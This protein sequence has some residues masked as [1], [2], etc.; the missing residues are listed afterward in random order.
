M[1]DTVVSKRADLGEMIWPASDVFSDESFDDRIRNTVDARS[2]LGIGHIRLV[3]IEPD[4]RSSIVRCHTQIFPLERTEEYTAL[5][6]TWGSTL[7]SQPIEIDGRCRLIPKNLWRFL[8]QARGCRYRFS[9]WLWIDMLSIDQTC[10]W[11]RRHQVNIMADIFK[12]AKTVV[13]WAGPAYEESDKAFEALSKADLNNKKTITRIHSGAAGL[14]IQNFCERAYWRRLWVFQELKFARSIILMCGEKLLP[15]SNFERFLLYGRENDGAL[16]LKDKID[17]MMRSPAGAM[18]ELILMSI[19]TSLW[20]LLL[21]TRH[22]RCAVPHDKVYALLS[23]AEAGHDGIDADYTMPMHVLLNRILSNMHALAPPKGLDVVA[24]Q[25]ENL[26]CLLGV[27]SKTIFTLPTQLEQESGESPCYPMTYRLGP[28]NS[29]ISLWWTARYNHTEVQR[30]LLQTWDYH[31]FEGIDSP[32]PEEIA[33]TKATLL[34]CNYNINTSPLGHKL[35]QMAI[36]GGNLAVVKLLL[37]LPYLDTNVKN[38]KGQS[39]LDQAVAAGHSSIV[40]EL[41]ASGPYKVSRHLNV[42]L[43]FW[44]TYPTMTIPMRNLLK[45]AMTSETPVPTKFEEEFRVSAIRALRHSEKDL[46]L[47]LRLELDCAGNEFSDVC[48]NLVR[49]R[50]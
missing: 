43:Q 11:E 1:A 46:D 37:A 45:E 36:A 25:C 3:K 23:V 19:D 12:S 21:A 24:T 42:D 41:I 4:E 47:K 31:W 48:F 15:W 14:A 33:A 28:S 16:R 26:E 30:L 2:I 40:S 9:G 35:L 20:A 7:P 50:Q 32:E 13:V 27:S 17:G 5:S 29:R 22:L 44:N 18:V 39:P 34:R 8:R 6:Y 49:T 38:D 10:A